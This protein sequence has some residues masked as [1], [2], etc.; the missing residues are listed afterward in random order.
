MEK[1]EQGKLKMAY[2]L[3]ANTHKVPPSPATETILDNKPEGSFPLS[4][5]ALGMTESEMISEE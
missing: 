5:I 3:I 2:V 1:S 4:W